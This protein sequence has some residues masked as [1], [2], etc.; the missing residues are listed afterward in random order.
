MSLFAELSEVTSSVSPVGDMGANPSRRGRGAGR[1]PDLELR[2]K[3]ERE[4]QR[5]V[6]EWYRGRGYAVQYLAHLNL[7]WD[8]HA[9]LADVELRI[10]VEGRSGPIISAELTPNEYRR[11][12]EQDL[13]YRI[14]IVTDALDP[15]ER[16]IHHFQLAPDDEVIE[17][18]RVYV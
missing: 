17:G 6:E 1:Q 9:H 8:V 11:V 2:Q 5:A 14:C 12:R 16:K 10:E 4:A 15:G 3:V 13:T 7:G 18:A